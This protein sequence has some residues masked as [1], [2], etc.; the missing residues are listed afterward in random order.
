MC[1]LLFYLFNYLSP[2]YLS[3]L[4]SYFEWSFPHDNRLLQKQL[5]QIPQFYL[6]SFSIINPYKKYNNSRYPKSCNVYYHFYNGVQ[7]Q[8]SFNKISLYH[9]YK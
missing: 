8:R 6:L 5:K 1:G 3:K 7:R 9:Y 4:L 2:N